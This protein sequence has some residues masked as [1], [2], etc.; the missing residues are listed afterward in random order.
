MGGDSLLNATVDLTIAAPWRDGHRGP[1]TDIN[2]GLVRVQRVER[3]R[4]PVTLG[5]DSSHGSRGSRAAGA[6]QA[7][8]AYPHRQDRHLAQEPVHE[9]G[10]AVQ[11]NL[12]VRS[13][14]RRVGKECRSRW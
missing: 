2:V 6:A 14:E 3:P 7:Q 5:L 1:E 12:D 8:G 10:G 11:G 9:L 4:S 13:E